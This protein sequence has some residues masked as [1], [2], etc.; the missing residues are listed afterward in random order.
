MRFAWLLECWR[1]FKQDTRT[2][3]GTK[4][5]VWTKEAAEVELGKPIGRRDGIANNSVFS[6]I[7]RYNSP[8]ANFSS[9]ELSVNRNDKKV[10]AAYFYYTSAVSWKTLE[11][12]LG[13]NFKKQK[14]ANG[15]PI[16]VYSF[17]GRTL[18]ILVDSANN[19]YNLGVW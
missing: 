7:F 13:T 14:P 6:D 19:V 5:G 11:E 2:Y 18:S 16:Y 1:K 10:R 15:R 4:M 8:V 12:K 3:I 17:Q 9:I